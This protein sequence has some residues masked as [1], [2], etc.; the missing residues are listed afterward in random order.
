MSRTILVT[1]IGSFS[2]A[3]VV[4]KYKEEGFR[5]IGCDIYPAEWIATSTE[6]DRFYQAPL[7]ADSQKFGAFLEKVCRE[8][9]VD[10]LIP[11][12]DVEVDAVQEWRGQAAS[13]GGIL[14]L[15]DKKTIRLCRNKWE[16][17][18]F[19]A[20]KGICKTIPGQV[21]KEVIE[22]EA[23][24]GYEL[25]EYPLVL[26]PFQGRSS[27]GMMRI[28]DARQMR[29]AAKWHQQAAKNYLVQPEIPGTVVTVDVVREPESGRIVTVSRREL[30][31][32][33]N[34]AGTSVQVF[35]DE[36]LARQC[37]AIA[38]ML[39]IRGCVNFEFVEK[40]PGEWYFLECNPRFSGGVAFSCMAGYDMV[41]NHLYCFTGKELE[42]ARKIHSQ[43]LVKR[44]QEYRT[45]ESQTDGERAKI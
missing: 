45:G 23:D 1:A 18:R 14:C 42:P 39:N 3:V 19:L 7:A 2:A 30:L 13:L 35:F 26:K 37:E 17:E 33:P 43:Y 32:T 11:L 5:V 10:Y 22:K 12:T 41:K 9:E 16:T 8:N 34:G 36:R 44:Y 21:L 31:R 29:Y 4:R 27:Q 40:V 25:L 24:T 15:S 28:Q 38:T 20:P 6:V